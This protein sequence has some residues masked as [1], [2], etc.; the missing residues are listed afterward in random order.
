MML[1]AGLG[2]AAGTIWVTDT[3][4]VPRENMDARSTLE[5]EACVPELR[6]VDVFL[7]TQLFNFY[8]EFT[9]PFE[10]R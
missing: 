10:V 6:N 4:T 1:E 9:P 3:R 5:E 7:G 2:G 8:D